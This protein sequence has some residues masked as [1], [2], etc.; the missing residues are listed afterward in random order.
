MSGFCEY[1]NE[2]SE[3]TLDYVR[4]YHTQDELVINP[5]FTKDLIRRGA[6]E[7]L[8]FATT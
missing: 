8:F 1:G 5:L 3:E 2:Y 6:S 4:S 7:F